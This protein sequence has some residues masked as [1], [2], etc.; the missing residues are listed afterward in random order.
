VD[1]IDLNNP[2]IH[3]DGNKLVNKWIISIMESH[4]QSEVMHVYFPETDAKS[5]RKV[6]NDKLGRGSSKVYDVVVP[7]GTLDA[8]KIAYSYNFL[9]VT[10]NQNDLAM[11]PLIWPDAEMS[12]VRYNAY[13][14]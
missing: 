14:V 12:L 9:I 3:I 5:I 10:K 8:G 4:G 1:I 11:I 6:L 7:Y 2:R 13:G